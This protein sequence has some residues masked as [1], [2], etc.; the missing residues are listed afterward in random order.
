MSSDDAVVRMAAIRAARGLL[1]L[2]Q[3]TRVLDR[4][5]ALALDSGRARRRTRRRAGRAEPCCRRAPCGRCSRSSVTT[6]RARCATSS[7]RPASRWTI[8]SP[9]WKKPPTGGWPGSRS[10]GA[11]GLARR[12]RRAAVD[13]ASP[14]RKG[15]VERVGGASR[16]PARLGSRAWGAPPRAGAASEHRRPVRPARGART[17]RRPAAARLPEASRS[18][19]TPRAWNRWRS[20]SWRPTRWRMRTCGGATSPTVF[21]RIVDAKG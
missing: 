10:G 5:T 2:P 21:H 16:T 14:H 13:T 8:R 1:S 11:P 17:A 3:G 12:G 19:A 15:P 6:P 20:R 4:L 7:R 18:L 9:N